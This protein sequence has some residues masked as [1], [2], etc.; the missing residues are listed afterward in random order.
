MIH[1]LSTLVILIL[2]AFSFIG[3]GGGS[4]GA[5]TQDSGREFYT[6]EAY[7]ASIPSDTTP[8]SN[9]AVIPQPPSSIPLLVILLEY[10]NQQIV[11]DDATWAQKFFSDNPHTL[12]NYY[13]EIS[14]DQFSF[15]PASETNGTQDD[16]IIKTALNKDHI[17]TPINDPDFYSRLADDINAS[18]NAADVSI[19]FSSFDTDNDG[20]LTPYELSI[21]FIIAGY[22][23]AYAGGHITNGIWAHQRSLASSDAPTLDGVKVCDGS[24]GGKFALFGERH[25]D[26]SSSCDATIG[27]IAHELGHE[28]FSLPDLYNTQGSYGGIGFFGLMGAGSWTRAQESENHGDTPVHMSAWSKAFIGW[29][30]PQELS[31]TTVTLDESSSSSY[32]VVKIPISA[33]HYYLL[34]NRNDSGYDKGL[35]SLGRD[36]EGGM[37]IWH[38]NQK[39][40]TTNNFRYNNVNA[41][42]DDKGVDVVEA[43]E[44]VL[45]TQ[46]NSGGSQKAFFYY[47]NRSSFGNKV[48]EIS[49]PGTTM[50]F[51]IH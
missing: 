26:A 32:N 37:L 16:G 10:N 34:E 31:D 5:N 48:T 40:L 44:P 36:F 14:Q 25:G 13:K 47:S 45:D 22:E 35:R 28:I 11:S 1:T 38:I 24:K 18:L 20:A 43:M 23:D 29:I 2:F 42:V 19:D 51:N 27:V 15:T 9:L 50:T 8:V 49:D 30:T 7:I 17:N 12:N 33:N 4:G 21:I 39:K 46:P 6:G 3:C 41:D